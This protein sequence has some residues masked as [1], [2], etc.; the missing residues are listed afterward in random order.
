MSNVL[1]RGRI[2]PAVLVVLASMGGC[3]DTQEWSPAGP[4]AVAQTTS[5][6]PTPAG[7]ALTAIEPA[8][9]GTMGATL[10]RIF[11]TGLQGTQNVSFG[12]I[13]ATRV[14]W[15]PDGTSVSA[16]TPPGAVGTVDVVVINGSGSVTLRGAFTYGSAT[17][18]SITA[19]S[20]G[21]GATAGGTFLTIHGTGFQAGAKV[22]VGDL[23]AT[24]LYQ[25][26]ATELDLYTR[27]HLAGPVDVVVTNPDGQAVRVVARYTYSRPEE[28][29]FNGIWAGYLG[30]EGEIEL[31]FK[32]KN[33]M[34][35][36]LSCNGREKA[37]TLTSTSSGDFSLDIDGRL[38]MTGALIRADRAEGI[39][40]LSVCG[41]YAPWFATRQ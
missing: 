6:A 29:N 28:R 16:T 15:S 25:T 24:V 4:S 34:L 2:L 33:D 35:V 40:N 18:V 11:G 32:V 38:A 17:P 7:L 3:G 22:T 30:I 5:P 8:F 14:G 13:P 20:P 36:S 39:A 1:R 23:D 27:P 31:G 19:V 41:S 10:V 9:G 37:V 21:A 12:G 26:L